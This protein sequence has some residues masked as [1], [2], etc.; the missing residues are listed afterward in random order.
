MSHR[1]FTL[2]E[3][4]VVIAIVAVLAGMLL[5]AVNLVRDAARSMSCGNQLRQVHLAE[6][7]YLLD[8]EGIIMPTLIKDPGLATIG[9]WYAPVSGSSVSDEYLLRPYFDS[10]EEAR[11]ILR[12]SGQKEAKP[13]AP[14]VTIT[15][16]ARNGNLGEWKYTATGGF[17]PA[18]GAVHQAPV[19]IS[20][21][22]RQ[23]EV[24]DLADSAYVNIGGVDQ[25]AAYLWEWQPISRFGW[26]HRSRA[27]VVYVDGHLGT[28]RSSELRKDQLQWY[29]V[30]AA[31]LP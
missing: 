14:S 23:S 4:L 27:N 8:W 3:L 16:Y 1:A 12:C 19:T 6:Q 31:P 22:S 21:I 28:A 5:P 24:V 13:Y 17:A 30:D 25:F 9:Q 2:I 7:G 18:L 11:R 15:S 26:R 20:R 10:R 29:V